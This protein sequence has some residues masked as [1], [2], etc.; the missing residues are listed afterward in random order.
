MLKQI[1]KSK[2]NLIYKKYKYIYVFCVQLRGVV[3]R[4][5]TCLRTCTALYILN[6]YLA[7]ELCNFT[8]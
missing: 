1:L 7:I 8:H 4:Y 6:S 2:M 3:N 5:S